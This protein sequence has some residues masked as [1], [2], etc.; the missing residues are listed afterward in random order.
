[1]AILVMAFGFIFACSSTS[2]FERAEA[3]RAENNLTEALRA[4]RQ[5]AA[6]EPGNTETYMFMAEVIAQILQN[7]AHT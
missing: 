3:L 1:M 7:R 2:H 4:A 5:A 6:N